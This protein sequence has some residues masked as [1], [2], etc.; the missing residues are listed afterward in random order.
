MKELDTPISGELALH[1]ISKAPSREFP[2]VLVIMPRIL[3]SIRSMTW[4]QQ[5]SVHT[6]ASNPYEVIRA[7][8][9]HPHGNT[10]PL[11]PQI[12]H[13]VSIHKKELD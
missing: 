10:R 1:G 2:D 5:V 7:L 3:V 12:G 6:R 13:L 9:K 11:C 4:N 8:L